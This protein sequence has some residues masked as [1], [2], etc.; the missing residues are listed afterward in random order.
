MTATL[1]WAEWR[2]AVTCENAAMQAGSG[3]GLPRCFENR[4]KWACTVHYGGDP[5]R[6]EPGDDR[7]ELCDECRR[8]LKADANRH[9]YAVTAEP[10]GPLPRRPGL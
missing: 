9:G 5:A 8:A 1:T 3:V 2:R 7:L 6:V 10:V 4:R